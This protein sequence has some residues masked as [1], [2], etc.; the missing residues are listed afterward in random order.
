MIKTSFSRNF[1]SHFTKSLKVKSLF[2]NVFFFCHDTNVANNIFYRSLK[3]KDSV[4]DRIEFI[5]LI[6]TSYS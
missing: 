5:Q 1:K 6:K 2:R 3:Y 4:Q